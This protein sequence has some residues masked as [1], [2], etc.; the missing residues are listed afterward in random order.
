MLGIDMQPRRTFIKRTAAIAS[1]LS[2]AL[3]AGLGTA[4]RTSERAGGVASVKAKRRRIIWNNDGDDLWAIAHDYKK[5]NWPTRYDSVEQFLRM[6][7]SAVKGTQVDSI[8]FCGFT[9]VPTWEFPLKNMEPLGPNPLDHVVTFAHQNGM[10]FMYSIR[11]NDVHC[12]VYPGVAYWPAFKLDNLHLLQAN[13]TREDFEQR[14]WPWVRGTTPDHPLGSLL[15]WW[16]QTREGELIERFR[17]SSLGPLAFSWPAYDYAHPEVRDHFLKVVE[18]ACQHYD[19]DGIEFDFGRHPLLFKYGEE[20]RNVPLMTDFIRRARQLIQDASRK[21]GKPILLA[22]RVPDTLALSLSVGLDVETWIGEGL[23]DILVPGFGSTPFSIPMEDWVGLGHQHDIPVYGSLSWMSLFAK[24]EAIRAAAYRL[25][26]E[27]VD[28]IY[29]FNLLR[30]EQFGCLYEIGDP[31]QLSRM[32]KLYQIDPDRKKVGYMNSSCLP[33]QVP[34]VFSTQSGPSTARLTL[35]IADHS[36][37]A[38]RVTIQTSWNA[39]VD[40]RRTALKLNGE[41]LANP[42]PLPSDKDDKTAA[43]WSEFETKALRKGV[44]TFHVTVQPPSAGAAEPCVLQ[45]LR[46]SI[47]YS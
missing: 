39:G 13:I 44:N 5:P 34:L 28:G 31:K 9:D 20:R 14:F 11:M 46:V 25:W 1:S 38:S 30:P 35:K 41:S 33:G 19:V 10:E 23:L 26:D 27:G 15:G 40:G 8:S 32:S 36:E 29:F 12:A 6:R 45:Q 4:C 22:M 17:N 2:L 16:G 21:K 3:Q 43:V 18:G 42:R 37:S 7:T 47:S 24:P